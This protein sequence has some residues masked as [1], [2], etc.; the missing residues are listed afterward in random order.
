[1]LN[2]EQQD[3]YNNTMEYLESDN[4]SD[5][6]ILT[7]K[8]GTGKTFLVGEIVKNFRAQ[9]AVAAIS[10]KAK[11]IILSKMSTPN[12]KAFTIA[13]LLGMSMNPETGEFYK[14]TYGEYAPI[15][16]Y[17]YIIIDECSMI[18]EQ[19]LKLIVTHKNPQTKII[20]VGDKGQIPPIRKYTLKNKKLSP[21]FSATYGSELH[22]RVRQGKDHPIL[23]YSDYY[24]NNANANSPILKNLK[25]EDIVKEDGKGISYHKTV[26]EAVKET[27]HLFQEAVDTKNSNLIKAVTYRNDLRRQINRIIRKKLFG[28]TPKDFEIG[29]MLIMLDNFSNGESNVDNSVE[30]SV[31]NAVKRIRNIDAR[32]EIMGV[33][34]VETHTFEYY[35]ITAITF[36]GKIVEVP[37]VTPRDLEAFNR[38]VARTF[39]FAKRQDGKARKSAYEEAWAIK[40]IFANC[41]FAYAITAHKS[42]GSTYDTVIVNVKDMLC[43]P[44]IE[45]DKAS[46]IYTAMTRA[47]RRAYMCGIED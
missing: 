41:D 46:L 13:K 31:I 32:V 26:N 12:V 47:S 20:F 14:G 35:N 21:T 3:A 8:A 16:E 42:Q 1:M 10:H 33:D 11:E 30:F 43:A 7:G 34:E 17:N 28:E 45:A 19:T 27:L 44:M 24:W 40:G 2:K 22:E 23:L 25:R 37:I 6:F 36:D 15:F 29:D 38:L 9:F 4:Y 18:D 39:D 5:Y